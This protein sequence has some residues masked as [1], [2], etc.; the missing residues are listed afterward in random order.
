[1]RERINGIRINLNTATQDELVTMLGHTRER[2]EQAKTDEYLIRDYMERRFGT[3]VTS[4]V[5]TLADYRKGKTALEF[6]LDVTT[7][8]FDP[9]DAA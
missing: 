9:K 4:R 3:D 1:M 5:V 7:D 8:D 2:I 6:D